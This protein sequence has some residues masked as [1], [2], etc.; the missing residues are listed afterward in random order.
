M[1]IAAMKLWLMIVVMEFHP[2]NDKIHASRYDMIFL[3]FFVKERWFVPP[4]E[5]TGS[6]PK[7][8]QSKYNSFKYTLQNYICFRKLF[9]PT[10][11]PRA[12]TEHINA[13]PVFDKR[14]MILWGLSIA[15]FIWKSLQSD[16]PFRKVFSGLKSKW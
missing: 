11:W 3:V 9:T 1:L 15:I 8:N 4:I 7:Y 2:F 12:S 14:F 16:W 6:K 5:W 13:K 10:L